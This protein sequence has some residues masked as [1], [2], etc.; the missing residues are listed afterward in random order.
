[1]DHNASYNLLGNQVCDPYY[2]LPLIWKPSELMVVSSTLGTLGFL[3][4]SVESS[5][6]PVE[7]RL[8]SLWGIGDRLG[9]LAFGGFL[10]GLSW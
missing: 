4:Y 2:A 5:K 6:L 1:M 8:D 3:A 9:L 7:S 10:S